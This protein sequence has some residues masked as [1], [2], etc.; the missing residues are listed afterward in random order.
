LSQITFNL[1]AYTNTEN[2]RWINSISKKRLFCLL[3]LVLSPQ[4]NSNPNPPLNQKRLDLQKVFI[5]DVA[6]PCSLLL[7]IQNSENYT[8][9]I[10]IFNL[11]GN[12]LILYAA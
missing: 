11:H 5:D 6:A 4:P 1:A 7:L 12:I 10:S 9:R 8:P 2:T 3:L